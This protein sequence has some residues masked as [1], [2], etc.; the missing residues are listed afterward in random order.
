MVVF[1][2]IMAML[3][4]MLI[5]IVMISSHR[6]AIN[7]PARMIIIP[8]KVTNFQK[9]K[10][11]LPV[12]KAFISH[13]H[14]TYPPKNELAFVWVF[15][16]FIIIIRNNMPNVCKAKENSMQPMSVQLHGLTSER[17]ISCQILGRHGLL[18]DWWDIIPWQSR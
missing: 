2:M 18:I 9:T 10:V 11:A 15:W 16:P 12:S 1:M 13:L 4:I 6:K 8:A 17:M 14:L 3:V 7:Q 5:M